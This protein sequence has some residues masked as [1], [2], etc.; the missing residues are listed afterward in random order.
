[1]RLLLKNIRIIES[2]ASEKKSDIL[3]VD[4]IIKTISEN[5]SDPDAM[6]VNVAGACVS[7]G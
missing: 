6:V 5:I 2:D 7:A 1:M 3:V 4:G